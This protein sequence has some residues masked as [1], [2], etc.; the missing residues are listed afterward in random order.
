LE[1]YINSINGEFSRNDNDT[2]NSAVQQVK[3][4]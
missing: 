2:D 1:N 3:K 4:E